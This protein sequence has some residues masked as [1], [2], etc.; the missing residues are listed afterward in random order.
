M[1]KK[2]DDQAFERHLKPRP[3]VSLAM[4]GFLFSEIVQQILKREKEATAQ[5]NLLD[6]EAQARAPPIP[7]LEKELFDLG[8]PVGERILEMQCYRDKGGSNTCSS[9][10]RELRIVNMLH[11]INNQIWK[12]LFGRPADGLE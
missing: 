2:S 7:D 3:E 11:F 5:I 1:V 4:F 10:K 9:G 6:A 8:K 12:S